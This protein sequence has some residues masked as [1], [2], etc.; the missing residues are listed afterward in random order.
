LETGRFLFPHEFGT[1]QF[2]TYI[3]RHRV[4]GQGGHRGFTIKTRYFP[5]KDRKLEL[6][7]ALA[8]TNT[9]GVEDPELN[10]FEFL[11]YSQLNLDIRYKFSRQLSGLSVRA[12]YFHSWAMEDYEDPEYIFNKSELDHFNLV[13]NYKF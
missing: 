11:S 8:E 5:L 12:L 9:S 2:Y 1:A 10:K 3:P 7:V 13:V 6:G 4:V